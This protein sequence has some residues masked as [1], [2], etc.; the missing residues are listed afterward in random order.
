MSG[1]SEMEILEKLCYEYPPKLEEIE[2]TLKRIKDFHDFYFY[3]YDE[4]CDDYVV[5]HRD[6][7]GSFIGDYFVRINEDWFGKYVYNAETKQY[8][9]RN[10]RYS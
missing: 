3:H 4:K 9:F 10:L 5:F 2:N 8:D 1:L 6:F 7:L